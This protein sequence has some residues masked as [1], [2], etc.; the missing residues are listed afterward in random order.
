MSTET[1]TVRMS[2]QVS[3]TLQAT[4]GIQSITDVFTQPM[5]LQLNNGA[6]GDA[7]A[8]QIYSDQRDLP[9]GTSYIFD[10]VTFNGSN[11]GVGNPLS[12]AV[13][14]QILVMNTNGTETNTIIT[15]GAPAGVR[16][17][18]AAT[19]GTVTVNGTSG[20]MMWDQGPAGY[21]VPA[22]G[23]NNLWKVANPG[24]STVNYKILV[25]GATS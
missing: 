1:L 20:W 17:W 8:N 19:T 11:D 15:G 16:G 25:I 5:L 10:L 7:L 24:A 9:A 2:G 23:G 13:V 14:K 3:A 6:G 21:A 22:G 18:T 4:V 12:M